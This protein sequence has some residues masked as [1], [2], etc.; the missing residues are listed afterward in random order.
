MAFY[1]KHPAW[2]ELGKTIAEAQEAVD[3]LENL[4]FVDKDRIA[5]VGY[6]QGAEAALHAAAFD[7]RVKAVVS[8]C[9]FSPLRT[10]KRMARS[11]GARRYALLTSLAPRMG[12]FV[13]HEERL[14]Y[15]YDELL[16]L[17]APRKVLIIDPWGDYW[18][19]HAGLD[20]CV[21]RARD[22]YRLHDAEDA[23][24]VQR[25]YD[26]RNFTHDRLVEIIAWLEEAFGN[27]E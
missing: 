27:A 12:F 6:C 24:T 17:I 13:G 23:L 7:T 16:G 5:I 1:R 10:E 25:P 9:G 18:T 22:V 14:P 21:A 8:L 4:T 15:D 20:A 19:D 11:V 2:S 26:N 3:L